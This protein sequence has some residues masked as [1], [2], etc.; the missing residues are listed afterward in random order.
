MLSYRFAVPIGFLASRRRKLMMTPFPPKTP[1]QMRREAEE[2]ANP[3]PSK[4]LGKVDPSKRP[5]LSGDR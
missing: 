1:A 5:I 2:R 3:R 4:P